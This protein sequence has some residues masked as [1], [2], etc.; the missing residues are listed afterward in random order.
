MW[1]APMS[2][3]RDPE[4]RS[5]KRCVCGG[6]SQRDGKGNL[7]HSGTLRRFWYRFGRLLKRRARE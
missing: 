1:R 2:S 4:N 7:R 5:E 6:H 3:C